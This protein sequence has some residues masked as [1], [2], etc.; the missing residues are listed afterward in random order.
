MILRFLFNT[1]RWFFLLIGVLLLFAGVNAAPLWGKIVLFGLGGLFLILALIFF[2]WYLRPNR[3]KTA[4][5]LKIETWDVVKD[6]MHNSNTDLI[7]WGDYFYLAHAVSPYHF[8][9]TGCHLKLS[10]SRD[11][12]KWESLAALKMPNED[13]RDPKL[14]VIGGELFIYALANRS[15]DPEPYTTVFA[16]S[17]DGGFNWSP[18]T[19][20]QQEGWL[21]WKPKT[22]DQITWVAAAYWHEHG[23][24]GLFSTQDGVHWE[25]VSM[26]H[27]GGMRNDETDVE[28][29][30]DGSLLSVARLEGDFQ[31]WGYNMFFGDP[32]GGTLVA[33]AP[34]P[35]QSFH[36]LVKSELTRL[37]GPALFRWGGRVFAVGRFQPVTKSPFARQGSIFA[38][39]RTALFEVTR[40]GLT[41]LT[42]VPSAG[43]TAYAGVA[44]L[45]D[46]LYFSYYTSPIERDYP[47]I[48]GM[49]NPTAIRMAKVD[50]NLIH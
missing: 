12:R 20:M 1:L 43:D 38:C 2:W 6:G 18:F 31:E 22:F 5:E 41:W 8:S 9:N 16:K 37:D 29:L 50:L 11:A 40:A 25:M 7:H 44:L 24:S 17:Q 26:I 45:H 47:W 30:P 33:D 36:P 27:A 46:T 4:P 10:R 35:Y 23:K 15:F 42:D 32:S 14:A 49:F 19:H 21:F 34:P 3:A 28:F 39:K 48:V 13:I